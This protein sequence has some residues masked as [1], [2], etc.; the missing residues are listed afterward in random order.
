M[1]FKR[2][3]L[4]R[5]A[6]GNGTAADLDACMTEVRRVQ[7]EHKL[8]STYFAS[9][10]VPCAEVLRRTQ[11]RYFCGFAPECLKSRD[12]A[13]ALALRN[14]A[15]AFVFVGLLEEYPLSIKCVGVVNVYQATYHGPWGFPP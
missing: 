8:P 4:L 9:L 3:F 13:L 14:V 10:R 15:A 11:L 6:Q 7:R 1:V 5:H 12:G 2:L